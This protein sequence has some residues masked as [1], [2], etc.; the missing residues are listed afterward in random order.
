MIAPAA[1]ETPEATDPEVVEQALQE[2]VAN[3][4]R[5]HKQAGNPIA[6]WRNGKVEVV[7]PE[8]IVVPSTPGTTASSG[9]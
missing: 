5:R 1:P 2:A 7:P 8:K 4:V 3:A 6:T 9:A